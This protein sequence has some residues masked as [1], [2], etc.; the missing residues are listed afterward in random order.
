[1][2]FILTAA[3]S[4]LLA[5]PQPAAAGGAAFS[6]STSEVSDEYG[7]KLDKGVDAFYRTDWETASAIFTELNMQN[8][9][10]PMPVFFQSM[11]P[12]WEYFFIDQRSES[13]EQFLKI[14]EQAVSLSRE[15]LEKSPGDT[16]MVLM[17]SGLYG[18][19]SLVAAGESNYRTAM[20]NGVT[21]FSYTRRLLS[22]G[23]DR[24]DARIGR[25]MFYYMVGSIPSG[26]RWATNM[27]GL[28]GDVEQGFSELKIAAES[29]SYVSN[30]AK[31][32]L[33]YLYDKEGRFI[34][35]L[36]YAELL[37]A[38]FPENVIFKF[39]K[40]QIHENAGNIDHAVALYSEIIKMDNPSFNRLTQNSKER[41]SE[42]DKIS[43]KH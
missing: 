17:L 27:A 38:K 36:T 18:Y 24:P 41:M 12:F 15:R 25:G 39:K 9:E 7:K 1:M 26:M 13:A 32:M 30:D 22:L 10:D 35:A 23:S 4:F 6:D 33:M 37:T 28:R 5:Q 8:P 3:L 16:T 14:S 20:Q 42:L 21:G 2:V 31:M 11:L 19:R 34:E 43:H 29:D 40:A